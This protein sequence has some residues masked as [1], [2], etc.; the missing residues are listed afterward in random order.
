MCGSSCPLLVDLEPILCPFRGSGKL[1]LRKLGDVVGQV[2]G[3]G[4]CF[5]PGLCGHG[6]I[7]H[8][9]LVQNGSTLSKIG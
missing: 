4:E 7:S 6:C 5:Y 9:K 8:I 1:I 3:S 2:L